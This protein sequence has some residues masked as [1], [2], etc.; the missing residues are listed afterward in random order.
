MPSKVANT[1]WHLQPLKSKTVR[2]ISGVGSGSKKSLKTR[3]VRGLSSPSEFGP[4]QLPQEAKLST[5]SESE[6]EMSCVLA[7]WQGVAGLE[8]A[9]WILALVVA[10]FVLVVA[11]V[12]WTMKHWR[13]TSDSSSIGGLAIRRLCDR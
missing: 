4:S 7:V 6:S 13:F 8:V 12:G 1:I 11:V 10:V 9:G 3:R 2:S 5:G